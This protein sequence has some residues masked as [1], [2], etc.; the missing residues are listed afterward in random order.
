MERTT[1]ENLKELI[2]AGRAKTPATK[3]IMGGTLV[4]VM[5]EEIYPADIAVYKDTIVAVGDVKEYIGE[6]DRSDRCKGQVSGAGYGLMVIFSSECSKLSIT[7]Y[8]K[9]VVPRGTTSMIS[10]L[11]EYISVSGLEGL[12]EVQ[13]EVQASPLKVF[14]G[15]PYKTPYTIPQSTVAFNFTKEVHEEVQKW[16]QCYGVWETVREFI[17]EEDENTLGAIA[18]AFKN[19]LPVIWMCTD[20]KRQ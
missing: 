5:S 20:G 14:W 12:Q 2:R 6:R 16:P 3:V 17:Q 9:A 11:D 10:G 4:N 15:A 18:E 7:S 8:A 1:V 19:R 13:K